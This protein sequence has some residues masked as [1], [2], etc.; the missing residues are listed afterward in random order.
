MP[1]VTLTGVTGNITMNLG[2]GD[3]TVSVADLTADKNLTI[4]GGDGDDTIDVGT[5]AP[6]RLPKRRSPPMPS[7]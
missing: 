3:V 5:I 6:P 4:T 2:A 1:S 7:P